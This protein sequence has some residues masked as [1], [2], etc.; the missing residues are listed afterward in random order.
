M[1]ARTG[2]PPDKLVNHAIELL[3]QQS[4]G[5]EA[6]RFDEWREAMLQVQGI[7]ANRNDLPNFSDIRA[8]MDRDLW[9]K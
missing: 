4:S 5:D 9:E 1:S 8:S 7:W 6:V 3:D 2:M